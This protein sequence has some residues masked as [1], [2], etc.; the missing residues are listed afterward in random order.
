[1]PILGKNRQVNCSDADYYKFLGY[2][3]NHPNDVK[4][5]WENN[6]LQGAWA[7]EGRVQFYSA[8]IKTFFPV[9]FLFTAGVNNIDSRL[10]CNDLILDMLQKGFIQGSNQ[11][12][13]TIR[14]N[15]PS[16]YQS[17]FDIGSQL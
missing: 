17:D 8:N 16:Q 15:I 7:S 1:M 6:Q 12:I 13:T 10:N 5:G 9:G 11:N 3:A 4:G 2:I 14:N